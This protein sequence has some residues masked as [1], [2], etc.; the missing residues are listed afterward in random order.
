MENW[1]EDNIYLILFTIL[2]GML[3]AVLV[4]IFAMYIFHI[5]T[6]TSITKMKGV[7]GVSN[8]DHEHEIQNI[9]TKPIYEKPYVL[10]SDRYMDMR[11]QSFSFSPGRSNHSYPK[12][13]G[14]R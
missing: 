9:P 3:C 11:S 2:I 12:R 1:E 6:L 10:N 7:E 14:T 13:L 4:I 5:K 8:I